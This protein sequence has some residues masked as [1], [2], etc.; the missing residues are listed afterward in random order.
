VSNERDDDAH[1]NVELTW[2]VA[3][4]VRP[5]STTMTGTL[6]IERREPFEDG[7]LA[8]LRGIAN[9]D[10]LA[11]AETFSAFSPDRVLREEH[12]GLIQEVTQHTTAPVVPCPVWRERDAHSLLI[13]PEK[14]WGSEQL[15]DK[16]MNSLGTIVGCFDHQLE[17]LGP[18]GWRDDAHER[19]SLNTTHHLHHVRLGERPARDQRSRKVMR[20][21]APRQMAKRAVESY[22][23]GSPGLEVSE[24]PGSVDRGALLG[25]HRQGS[26]SAEMRR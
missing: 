19:E 11:A 15:M 6:W 22:I 25:R 21:G 7:S 26:L 18:E 23:D 12:G 14:V 2:A 8:V 9:P 10:S 3:R 4:S 20:P 16:R 13:A 1:R 5:R 17:R 24:D